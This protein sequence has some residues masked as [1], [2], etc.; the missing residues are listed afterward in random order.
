MS[1]YTLEALRWAEEEIALTVVD[2]G[3]KASSPEELKDLMEDKLTEIPN[4]DDEMGE[5]RSALLSYLVISLNWDRIHGL[6]NGLRA[7]KRID[8]QQRKE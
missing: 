5:L 6:I 7:G 2:L 4:N 3:I 8:E 1:G